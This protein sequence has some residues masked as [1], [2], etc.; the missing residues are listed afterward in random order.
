MAAVNRRRF[1]TAAALTPFFAGCRGQARGS[2]IDAQRVDYG[3]EPRQYLE[4]RLPEGGTRPIPVVV[5]VHGGFWSHE[6]R[7][8]LM[9]PLVQSV[10]GGGRHATVNVEY[11]SVGDTGGGWP[12][13]LVDVAAAVDHLRMVDAELDLDA[14]TVVGHSAG[15]QL[16]AWLSARPRL[17]PGAPGAAPAVTPHVVVSL[18][19][20]LD[21]AAGARQ[22]LGGEACQE[23][24][25]GEPEA[26]P[27]RYAVASPIQLLPIPTSVACV[28]GRQDV[29]VPAEQSVTFADAAVASGSD[30]RLHLVDGDHF[31]VIDPDHESWRWVRET[32][33]ELDQAGG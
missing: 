8:D 16:A 24:L 5:F 21:L 23:F 22:R 25:G 15:G 18:A 26:V 30:V 14:V 29:H 7:A 4:L 3:D 12:G 10:V 28:H 31:D 1:L 13:T 20:V 19:G 6:Y 11:R 17:D 32:V 9:T 27:D 33:L 2:S